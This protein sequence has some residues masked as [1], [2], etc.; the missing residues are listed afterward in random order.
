LFVDTPPELMTHKQI[1]LVLPHSEL[2][3]A[4]KDKKRYPTGFQVHVILSTLSHSVSSDDVSSQTSNCS[5]AGGSDS[6]DDDIDEK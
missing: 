5:D 3:H 4:Y 2:D 6:S 1:T